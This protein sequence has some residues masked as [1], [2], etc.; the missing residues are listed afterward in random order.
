MAES[1][2][3]FQ[4][5]FSREQAW[6]T[7]Q[8]NMSEA[9]RLQEEIRQGAEDGSASERELLLKASEALGRLTDNTILKRIVEKALEARDSA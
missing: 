2:G 5:P 7:F 9:A 4:N 6:M 3:A 1:N 8:K